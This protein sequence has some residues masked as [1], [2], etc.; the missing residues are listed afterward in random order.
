MYESEKG[1]KEGGNRTRLHRVERLAIV[2]LCKLD[3]ILDLAKLH[4]D[5]GPVGCGIPVR[6]HRCVSPLPILRPRLIAQ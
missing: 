5:E 4:Q 6:T 2:C 3:R 1:R